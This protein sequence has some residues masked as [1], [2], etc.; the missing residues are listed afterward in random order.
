MTLL[1]NLSRRFPIIFLPF[2]GKPNFYFTSSI[3]LLKEIE[4]T[5]LSQRSG[6]IRTFHILPYSMER[7][8]KSFHCDKRRLFILVPSLFSTLGILALGK[9][10]QKSNLL[11]SLKSLMTEIS[12]EE[13]NGLESPKCDFSISPSLAEKLFIQT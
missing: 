8:V 5:L 3:S 12:L 2:G 10:F 4:F 13:L 7:I 1:E 9:L 11:D 6:T